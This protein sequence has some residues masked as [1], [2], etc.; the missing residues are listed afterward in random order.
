MLP[1]HRCYD[2]VSDAE[3]KGPP[4]IVSMGQGVTGSVGDNHVSSE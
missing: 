2:F 4:R 3:M 1:P